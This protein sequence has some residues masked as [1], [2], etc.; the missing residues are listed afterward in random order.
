M[1]FMHVALNFTNQLF[2]DPTLLVQHR[3]QLLELFQPGADH[4][5]VA[6][7]LS[8]ADGP[9]QRDLPGEVDRATVGRYAGRLPATIM[10]VSRAVVYQNLQRET[11]LGMTFA[12][13]P[14]YEHE[15]T[16]CESPATGDTPGWIT[17]L[18]RG[19]YPGDPHP[20][21]GVG[22]DGRP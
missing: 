7:L 4:N 16:V 17:I 18:M 8:S 15:I 19:R 3:D 12:W 1:P 21:T 11:P 22:I 6:S 20:I 2:G 14:A 13:M 9:L 10:E 5:A